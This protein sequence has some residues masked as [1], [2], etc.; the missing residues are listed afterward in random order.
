MKSGK[1]RCERDD[2]WKFANSTEADNCYKYCERFRRDMGL[3][4]DAISEAEKF[5]ENNK[6]Y[7]SV[8]C[9][10]TTIVVRI[11]GLE[12]D[13]R[14]LKSLR[15]LRKDH[16]QDDPRYRELLLKYDAL[17][18]IIARALELDPDSFDVAI[19]LYNIYLKGGSKLFEL[20]KISDAIALYEEMTENLIRKYIS[21]S[22]I[23]EKAKEKY[24]Q[25]N[26][27][28]GAFILKRG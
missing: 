13:D 28:H 6:S 16:M 27:G 23:P 9:Y 3:A 1:Y 21:T 25:K 18:P 19:D 17:G 8:G 10:V 26:G 14:V 2:C 5:Q 11:L 24:D 4:E 12:D 20:G 15:S 7:T 22:F